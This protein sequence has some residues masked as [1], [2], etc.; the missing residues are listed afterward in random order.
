M[1]SLVPVQVKCSK[2]STVI[3][4][5]AFLDPSSRK[6]NAQDQYSRKKNQHHA[7]YDE[8]GNVCANVLYIFTGLKVSALEENN[9]LTLP[10][11]Y[12]QKNTPIDTN[13]IPTKDELSRWAYLNKVRIPV[14]EAEVDLLIGDNAPKG[15]EPWEIVNSH[16]DGPYAVKTQLGWVVNGPLKGSSFT[17]KSGFPLCYVK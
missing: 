4:T 17:G 6:P 11:V 16:D 3:L 1:L 7:S 5:Y 8:L 13:S 15:I 10:E 14:I 2:G 9:L 12:T